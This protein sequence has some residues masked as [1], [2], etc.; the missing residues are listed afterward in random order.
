LASTRD[1]KILAWQMDASSASVESFVDECLGWNVDGLVCMAYKYDDVWP[2]AAPA[3]QRL[4]RLVSILGDPGVPGGHT[5]EID[6]A[7]SV[8]QCVE[9]LYRQGRHRIVQVL[10]GSK[11]RDDRQRFDAFLTAHHEFYG[12]A[13]EEQ[14]CFATEGWN[15]EEYG[16]YQE[17]A[18]EIVVER[19]ADAILLESDFSAPGIVRGVINLGRRIPEDV[20]LIG[21]GFESVGRGVTPSLTT[22][23]FDL[24]RVASQAMDLLTALIERPDEEQPRTILIEPILRLRETA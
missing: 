10:E 22:V 6:I 14:V 4:P 24:E 7:R 12:P 16:K 15:V 3:L 18:R 13:D 21:W 23:D 2:T 17:L 5:V 20:A 1:F 9:Y 8:R 19:G 11:V